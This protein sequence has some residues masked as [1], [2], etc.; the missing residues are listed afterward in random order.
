MFF[1]IQ[2]LCAVIFFASQ[3]HKML[4]SIEGNSIIVFLGA[5]VAF[6]I[7]LS[8]AIVVWNQQK[9]RDTK[10]LVVTY[11]MWSLF[12]AI[13]S[14]IAISQGIGWTVVD[15]MFLMVMGICVVVLVSVALLRSLP[16]MHP[17]V[18]C[19]VSII[20]KT[21]PQVALLISISQ[22]GSAGISGIW[23]LFG[24]ITMLTR[25]AQ[26]IHTSRKNWERSSIALAIAETINWLTWMATT[27]AF[28]V[29]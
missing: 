11:G 23:I 22:Q 26:I 28:W 1:Y 25:L 27:V 2:V 5:F 10:R 18:K 9:N 12:L 13:H 8:L 14:I 21:I 29:G 17:Y 24:H 16:I 19:G 7:Q 4:E 6:S 15:S 3:S 20:F